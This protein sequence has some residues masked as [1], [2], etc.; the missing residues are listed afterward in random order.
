MSLNP[1]AEKLKAAKIARW[2]RH[3]DIVDLSDIHG[4][5]LYKGGVGMT[6]AK[7]VEEAVDKMAYR[8]NVASWSAVQM[9]AEPSLASWATRWSLSII[10]RKTQSLLCDIRLCL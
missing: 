2:L 5:R 10:R 4:T 8:L 3:H 6:A 7:T 9:D 1:K